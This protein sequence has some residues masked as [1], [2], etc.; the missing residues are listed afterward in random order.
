MWADNILCRHLLSASSSSY[1]FGLVYFIKTKWIVVISISSFILFF[2]RS[3]SLD[4]SPL[5]PVLLAMNFVFSRI[6]A[7]EQEQKKSF[8]GHL[9]GNTH[10]L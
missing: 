2:A 6:C 8:D 7:C 5:C 4:S 1:F 10:Y 3:H 9:Y